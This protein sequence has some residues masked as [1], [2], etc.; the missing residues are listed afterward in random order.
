VNV[1][2]SESGKMVQNTFFKLQVHI[3]FSTE[4]VLVFVLQTLTSARPYK[5]PDQQFSQDPVMNLLHINSN[6]FVRKADPKPP[7][8]LLH[9]HLYDL[10]KPMWLE[11]RVL[12][13]LPV[14]RIATGDNMQNI[15]V[16]MYLLCIYL[17]Y[18]QC[19]FVLHSHDV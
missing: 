2:A 11:L 3:F 10:L 14:E 15:H 19:F 17:V 9:G 1:K 18:K 4:H 6:P 13:V 12:G 8:R 7:V 5:H 16:V